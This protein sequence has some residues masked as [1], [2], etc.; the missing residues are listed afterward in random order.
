MF[1]SHGRL[2]SGIMSGALFSLSGS[3][4]QCL[5]YQASDG[6]IESTKFC[7]AHL[8]ADAALSKS[9]AS[10][11]GQPEVAPVEGYRKV[12]LGLCVPVGCTSD[13]LARL[14]D[15]LLKKRVASSGVYCQQVECSE[16][17]SGSSWPTSVSGSL[18]SLLILG[19]LTSVLLTTILH[20]TRGLPKFKRTWL[21]GLSMAAGLKVLL[22]K[23]ADRGSVID[24]AALDGLRV[25][26]MF[27]IITLH[28]YSFGLQWLNFENTTQVDNV[29]KTVGTQWIANGTFSVDT[30]FVI[31][32]LL[33]ALRSLKEMQIGTVVNQIQIESNNPRLREGTFHVFQLALIR[34]L[35]RYLRLVPTMMILIAISQLLLPTFGSG[36]SW[37]KSTEMFDLWCR[38][39]WHINFF[40]LQNF[41]RT[42]NMCFSHSWYLAVDLQLFVT[43]QLAIILVSL[44][45]RRYPSSQLY[46]QLWIVLSLLTVATQFVVAA[47]VVLRKL[48]SIPLLPT[49]SLDSLLEYFWILYIKPHYWFASY[50]VGCCLAVYLVQQSTCQPNRAPQ[51]SL[52]MKLAALI[53]MPSLVWSAQAHFKAA[54]Q[55]MPIWLS[56]L[57]SLISRPLWSLSLA[58]LLH[59]TIANTK[60]R[61]KVGCRITRLLVTVLTNRAWLPLSRLSYSAYL[62]HPLVMACFY[63]SR[64]ESF[65]FSHALLL[66]FTLGN[67]IISYAAALLV[68]LIIE[69][70][71][72][73][74]IGRVRDCCFLR[75]SISL[76]P[77]WSRASRRRNLAATNSSG[78]QLRAR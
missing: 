35:N 30:F 56:S 76:W 77:T 75:P 16:L 54:P 51:A 10:L 71:A 11:L 20:L 48:I 5:S 25:L 23:R 40:M 17:A 34:C 50:A 69:T 36:P 64:T 78:Y 46:K 3:Y 21:E 53:I 52:S 66:Y 47:I 29:F 27:W 59:V 60:L 42:S 38:S 37:T 8:T 43:L 58:Y 9:S 4:E 14:A 63:G 41:L 44:I 33:A 74:T 13:D 22:R 68:Y 1:D 18:W 39:N 19:L 61:G 49:S 57:Y 62:L 31:G 6:Q 70:P 73:F 67:I 32:G 24:L 2:Q 15:L 72:Q 26:T 45:S 65:R 28:S 12:R 7:V 55:L